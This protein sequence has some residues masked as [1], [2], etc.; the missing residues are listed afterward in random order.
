MRY[1]TNE[2][3]RLVEAITELTHLSEEVAK[4]GEDETSPEVI[5]R[6][7]EE[8]RM[9]LSI[10]EELSEHLGVDLVPSYDILNEIEV[11]YMQS[12]A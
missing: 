2:Q 8:K 7:I 6:L 11:E 4:S 10:H 3:H 12:D 5:D 1:F 9:A